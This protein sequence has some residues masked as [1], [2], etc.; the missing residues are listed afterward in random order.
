MIFLALSPFVIAILL[1]VVYAF[2]HSHTSAVHSLERRGS[3]AQIFTFL[4]AH[5]VIRKA[6]NA[7]ALTW[8][9][10]Y[11]AK[12]ELWADACNFKL[13]EGTLDEIPYGELHTAATGF[14]DI[15][16]AI[17]QFA[18]DKDSYNPAKPTFNHFTQVVWKSTTEVGCARATC[19]DLFGHQTGVAT[20]YVCLYNPA[21]NVIGKAA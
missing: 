7:T 20:Y 1:P 14:F 6:H 9:P 19:S 8:S 11:A 21:G 18:K 3:P 5:N 10:A 16:T 12:A 2:G 17:G 13:T 15:T 4:T